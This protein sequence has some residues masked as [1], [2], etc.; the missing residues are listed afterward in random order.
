[1]FLATQRIIP[2]V[3][4]GWLPINSLWK[5]CTSCRDTPEVALSLPKK[6]QVPKILY[7]S[8]L[9]ILFPKW[10]SP[11][12]IDGGTSS[13]HFL[14]KFIRKT[15]YV[16]TASCSLLTGLDNLK[17]LHVSTSPPL[18]LP[19]VPPRLAITTQWQ[20]TSREYREM[21]VWNVDWVVLL[22]FTGWQQ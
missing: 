14:S 9:C 15:W 22:H 19:K 11:P 7:Q 6:H 21:N 13:L 3:T 10:C 12:V 8:R 2:I 18:Y 5:T 20:H 4:R 16:P 1:M 17:V